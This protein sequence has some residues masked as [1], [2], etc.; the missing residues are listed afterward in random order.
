G[1]AV[2]ADRDALRA[3]ADGD[4]GALLQAHGIA[5]DRTQF[6]TLYGVFRANLDNFARYRPQRLAQPLQACLVR[7][8]RT[9]AAPRAHDYGWGGWLASPPAVVDI[10][11]DH[12]SLLDGAAAQ[13]LADALRDCGAVPHDAATDARHDTPARRPPAPRE[14]TTATI[15]DQRGTT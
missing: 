5:M 13:R 2:R 10:D 12:F 9:D 6:D 1:V 15:T 4:A 11:A 3:L 7:A 14:T 8:T